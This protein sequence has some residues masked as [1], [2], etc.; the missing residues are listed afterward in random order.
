MDDRAYLVSILGGIILEVVV[1][2]RGEWDRYAPDILRTYT[3]LV[4]SSFAFFWLGYGLPFGA[5]VRV[6]T[7]HFTAL[8]TGLFGSMTTYRLFFH[9]LRAF[10]G[11][12]TA[13]ITSLWAFK[14]ST[15]KLDW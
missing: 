13:R 14:E 3:I 6:T 11:P 9:P 15:P 7:L 8:L 4:V 12:L 2:S 10:P 1:F 5:S